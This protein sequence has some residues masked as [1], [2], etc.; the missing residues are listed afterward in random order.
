MG[1]YHLGDLPTE[2][3]NYILKWVVSSELD[4]RSLENCALVCR[5][6]YIAARDQDIWR[7]ACL[8]VWGSAVSALDWRMMF[9][10][11]PRVNYSGCYDSKISYMREGERSFQDQQNYRAWHM[12]EYHR[13]LRF[14]PGNQVAMLTSANDDPALVAKQ[15][16]TRAGCISLGAMMG[17]YKIV[18]NVLVCVLKKAAPERKKVIS[19]ARGRA[20][21]EEAYVFEIPDQVLTTRVSR[22]KQHST[23]RAAL[24]HSDVW[25]SYGPDPEDIS[26]IAQSALYSQV[27]QSRG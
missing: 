17:Q 3:L 10:T 26:E 23:V 7:L 24:W 21:R 9:L 15:L 12:V 22:F 14:F 5:G 2:L 1:G 16:N 20:R 8:K 11:K 4:L 13:F 6:L 18:D 19:R 25:L 27:L